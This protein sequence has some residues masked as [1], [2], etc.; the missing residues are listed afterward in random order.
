MEGVEDK[1]GDVAGYMPLQRQVGF[2]Y[3]SPNLFIIAHELGH[4][5]FNLRHTFSPE[6]F[7]AAE[8]TTQNL[9]DYNGGTELWKHQWEFIRDPQNIW[10]AWAQ[11]ES[12]GEMENL[13]GKYTVYVGD[14]VMTEKKVFINTNKTEKIYVKYE[15]A[16]GDTGTYINAKLIYRPEWSHDDISWPATTWGKINVNTKTY[17][18]LDSLPE[19]RYMVLLKNRDEKVDTVNFYLR[20][21]KYDFACSVC[22][23]DLTI[24][25][26]K[27]DLVFPNGENITATLANYFNT[28]LKAAGFNTCKSHAHFFAQSYVETKG[29]TELAENPNYRYEGVL[30]LHN[31]KDETKL[32]FNQAFFDNNTHL[33]YFHFKVYKNLSDS[34]GNYT[35]QNYKTFKWKSSATDTVRVPSGGDAAYKFTKGLGTFDKVYFSLDEQKM[36]NKQ[37]FSIIYA[38]RYENGVPSTEDGYNYR[39]QGAIHL[40]YKENYRRVIPYAK[41]LFKEDFDWVN[42]PEYLENNEKDAVYSAVAYFYFRL[43]K[44]INK[45]N[46]WDIDQVSYNVNGGYNGLPQRK[47][48]YTRLSTQVFDL[49][50]CKK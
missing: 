45:L 8:R 1:G 41:E 15:P 47:E 26:E 12:E 34:T 16:A 24:T 48:Q 10:F 32:F 36:R 18:D 9:M 43:K 33:D 50:G 6:S 20:P 21:K 31:Q 46:E 35:G 3:D 23:R 29:Y 28:A 19:G 25:K 4:G 5:A 2:I 11:E 13:K 14:S 38:N 17:F 7:I 39:G 22:G 44:D 37:L 42:H 49:S 30:E 40:T 27:L